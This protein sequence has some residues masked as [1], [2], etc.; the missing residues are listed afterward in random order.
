MLIIHG[1]NDEEERQ[2]YANSKKAMKLLPKGSKL[3]LVDGADHKFYEHLDIA[4]KLANN[5][6]LEHIEP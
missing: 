3:E 1:N 2:L 4:V 6:F 5:W